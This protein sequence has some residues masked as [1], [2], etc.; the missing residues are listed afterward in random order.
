VDNLRNPSPRPGL[1]VDQANFA[2]VDPANQ[3]V[4]KPGPFGRER[5][6]YALPLNP[7][8]ALLSAPTL[9]RDAGPASVADPELTII[10]QPAVWVSRMLCAGIVED[11]RRL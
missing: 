6:L 5:C 4:G 11:T 8:P 10:G 1:V 7:G 3:F 2:L 9:I